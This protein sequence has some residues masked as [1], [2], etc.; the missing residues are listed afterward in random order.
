ME[1]DSWLSSKLKKT[2]K[3]FLTIYLVLN[4]YFNLLIF[5]HLCN[6]NTDGKTS[7]LTSAFWG[8]WGVTSLL[9]SKPLAVAI[10]GSKTAHA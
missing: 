1:L 7:V 10:R 8:L 2:T 4:N 6:F 9:A 3:M 5:S